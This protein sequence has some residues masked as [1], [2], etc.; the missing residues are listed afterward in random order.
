MRRSWL[1]AVVLTLGTVFTGA[2]ALGDDEEAGVHSESVCDGGSTYAMA[3][4]PEIGLSFEAEIATEPTTTHPPEGD[5]WKIEIQYND[6]FIQRRVGRAGGGGGVN[7]RVVVGNAEGPDHM[8]MR[9]MNLDTG[10]LCW[11]TLQGDL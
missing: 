8:E 2:S 10:E 4:I 11:G 5:R 7:T 6:H 3:I 1:L 9:A